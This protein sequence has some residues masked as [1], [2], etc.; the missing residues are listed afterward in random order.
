M[1]KHLNILA[2]LAMA[3]ASS[4]AC[5]Q[6]PAFPPLGTY[7]Q[8]PW[9]IGGGAGTGHLARSGNDLT[10]LNNATLDDNDTAWTIRGGWR[11]SPFGA[12]ELGYYDFGRYSFHGTAVGN[13][14]PIDGSAKAH[15][16]A[17]SLVG[18][19]P[20]YQFDL[21]GRIG[22]AHSEL[23]FN[24]NG[25]LGGVANENQ[26]QDEATYGLG[27]RWNFSPSVSVFVEWFKNDRIRVDSVVGG[28]DFRF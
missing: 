11:F 20:I 28:L 26:R 24:A 5:A 7:P 16:V 22:Y 4:L 18:I 14:V 21:Y 19:L 23:K 2:P 3:C 12:V 15:S 9:Y 13:F 6:T 10:G 8:P 25:P 27:G 1:K 17:I